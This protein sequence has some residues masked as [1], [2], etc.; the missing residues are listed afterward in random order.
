MQ[1][2]TTIILDTETG[3]Y[4]FSVG[5]RAL[6]TQVHTG[7]R[8]RG[9]SPVKFFAECGFKAKRLSPL[10]AEVQA[11]VQQQAEEGLIPAQ[12]RWW[13]PQDEGLCL[14]STSDDY[15]T[16]RGIAMNG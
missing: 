2:P 9:F 11:Y 13:F 16:A 6:H 7:G 1:V 10:L 4:L 15:E 8:E 3:W 5:Y 14:I 12:A